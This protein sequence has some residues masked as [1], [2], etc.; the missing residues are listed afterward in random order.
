MKIESTPR[1]WEIDFNDGGPKQIISH[2][3][4]LLRFKDEDNG[5]IMT[6]LFALLDPLKKTQ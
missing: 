2:E 6:P 3:Y 5:Y 1:V 4:Y